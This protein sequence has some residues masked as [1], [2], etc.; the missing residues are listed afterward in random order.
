[1]NYNFSTCSKNALLQTQND[2]PNQQVN[3]KNNNFKRDIYPVFFLALNAPSQYNI[4]R[5]RNIVSPQYP[6]RLV[7]AK[8]ERILKMRYCKDR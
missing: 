2:V 5:N 6:S 7:H 4:K 1:M 3:C 8:K